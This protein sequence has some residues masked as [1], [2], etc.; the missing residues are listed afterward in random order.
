MI[1]NNK[2]IEKY[3]TLL[4]VHEY[5]SIRGFYIKLSYQFACLKLDSLEIIVS[6]KIN[7]QMYVLILLKRWSYSIKDTKW[8]LQ[9]TR[10]QP[11]RDGDSDTRER[12]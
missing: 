8:E 7:E 12:E 9:Q 11:Q 4:Y 2:M 6:T 5:I 10:E 3:S 1:D